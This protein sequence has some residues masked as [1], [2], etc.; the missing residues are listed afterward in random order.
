M[1]EQQPNLKATLSDIH[2]PSLMALRARALA[3]TGDVESA[4]A[5]LSLLAHEHPAFPYATGSALAVHAMVALRQGD[6]PL[7]RALA[8]SRTPDLRLPPHVATLLDLLAGEAGHFEAEGELGRIEA[9]LSA[10]P[11]VRAWI[12][13]LAPGLT[14][15][16]ARASTTEP[17]RIADDAP[18]AATTGHE[19]DAH[20]AGRRAATTQRVMRA[21]GRVDR[22]AAQ[23]LRRPGAD[24]QRR[25]ASPHR[26][27]RR[28]PAA[29]H[30]APPRRRRHRRRVPLRRLT[31]DTA[32]RRATAFP[33]MRAQASWLGVVAILAVSLGCSGDADLAQDGERIGMTTAAT[34]QVVPD[35]SLPNLNP[36]APTPTGQRVT[37]RVSQPGVGLV[38]RERHVRLLR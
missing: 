36:G 9:E 15:G 14:P 2:R 4:L 23:P 10:Q 27:R 26:L 8:A 18:T 33:A 7:A 11:G 3:A 17:V 34:G 29:Q 24:A 5:E 21:R 38:L 19:T 30:M 28:H 16:L 20:T 32:R 22:R 31:L 6:R 13:G 25:A 35:F 37:P 1:L 12:E